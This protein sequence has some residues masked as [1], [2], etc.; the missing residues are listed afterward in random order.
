M[1]SWPLCNADLACSWLV[2]A[3]DTSAMQTFHACTIIFS[4]DNADDARDGQLGA[5]T[6]EGSPLFG[7]VDQLD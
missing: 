5:L 2:K 7:K 4:D 3:L 6:A 1:F